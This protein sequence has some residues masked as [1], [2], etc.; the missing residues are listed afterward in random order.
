MKM[1][2]N[3]RQS[4]INEIAEKKELRRALVLE[5]V[6]MSYTGVQDAKKRL[7]QYSK[8]ITFLTNTLNKDE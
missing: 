7:A 3:E 2:E 4:I 8:R 1:N 5:S 6:T